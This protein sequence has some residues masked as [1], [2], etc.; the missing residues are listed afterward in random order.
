M[1]NEKKKAFI[2]ANLLHQ[3]TKGKRNV[4]LRQQVKDYGYTPADYVVDDDGTRHFYEEAPV[5][6]RRVKRQLKKNLPVVRAGNVQPVYYY[7][8]RPIYVK[9]PRAEPSPEA[10]GMTALASAIPEAA[11]VQA[12]AQAAGE[13]AKEVGRWLQHE[14]VHVTLD[15]NN[16]PHIDDISITAGSILAMGGVAMAAYTIYLIRSGKLKWDPF[17]LGQW[18]GVLGKS[19]GGSGNALIDALNKVI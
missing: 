11:L 15:E 7:P 4:T 14:V 17:G 2:K 6:K 19:S 10:V 18:G 13:A 3:R 5:T 8:P 1:D 12:G 16:D 9:P